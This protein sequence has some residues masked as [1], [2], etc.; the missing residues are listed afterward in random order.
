MAVYWNG[1]WRQGSD[2]AVAWLWR[3]KGVVGVGKGAKLARWAGQV[4]PVT[5]AERSNCL[6]NKGFFPVAWSLLRMG[7]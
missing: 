1:W 7:S 2:P 6:W 5:G 4:L 3:G